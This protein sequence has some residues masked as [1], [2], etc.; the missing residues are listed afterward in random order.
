MSDIDRSRML[1]RSKSRD[2]PLSK[3]VK[4]I[5]ER[6]G[7]EYGAHRAIGRCGKIRE[8][9]VEIATHNATVRDR[10]ASR[11]QGA[12]AHSRVINGGKIDVLWRSC[13]ADPAVTTRGRHDQA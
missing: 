3:G 1:G 9:T 11:P 12:S 5:G 2:I 7:S 13:Q 4:R 8:E 10:I 6:R